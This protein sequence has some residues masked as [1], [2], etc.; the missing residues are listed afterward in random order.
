[1]PFDGLAHACFRV[2]LRLFS[3]GPV[4][5]KYILVPG[6]ERLECNVLK[7]QSDQP[8]RRSSQC[9]FSR[10]VALAARLQVWVG[11]FYQLHDAYLLGSPFMC[12]YPA[13]PT[14]GSGAYLFFFFASENP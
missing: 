11:S 8:P 2:L 3:A 7:K 10:A 6:P 4:V 9:R 12:P 13:M 14:E 5:R 1:M